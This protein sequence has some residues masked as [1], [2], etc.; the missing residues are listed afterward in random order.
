MNGLLCFKSNIDDAQVVVGPDITV[1]GGT[2]L[3]MHHPDE[4]DED[5][6]D[7]EF[8]SDDNAV[9]QNK[10]KTKQKGLL[11]FYFP[12]GRQWHILNPS[13]YCNDVCSSCCQRLIQQ[14]WVLKEE[15]TDGKPAASRIRR[16]MN[17]LNAFG[18]RRLS[19]TNNTT[20][21]VP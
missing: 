17:L 18:V 16:K 2:V 4:E 21:K 6:D 12:T 13:L 14:T 19:F 10:D 1:P 5:D 20:L 11:P 8:M 15:D 7:D 3:S 9:G